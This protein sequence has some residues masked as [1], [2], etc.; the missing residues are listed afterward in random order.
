MR[1]DCGY[2]YDPLPRPGREP[3]DPTRDDSGLPIYVPTG[4]LSAFI[5]A[6][7]TGTNGAGACLVAIAFMISF[8]AGGAVNVGPG[9]Y[10]LAFGLSAIA[11][12]FIGR[13]LIGCTV[14]DVKRG[15]QFMVFPVWVLGALGFVFGASILAT[16][17]L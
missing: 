14:V 16:R 10:I 12:D 1:C 9:G 7:I 13:R 11:L 5:L 17:V 15:P 3:A 6:A 4:C 2:V 8:L